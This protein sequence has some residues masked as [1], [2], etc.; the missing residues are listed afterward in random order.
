MAEPWWSF[1]R[2]R[3]QWG[4]VGFVVASVVAGVFAT[5]DLVGVPLAFNRASVELVWLSCL[6][7]IVAC[8]VMAPPSA[9]RERGWPQQPVGRWRIL[10]VVFLLCFPFLPVLATMLARGESPAWTLWFWRNHL[11]LAGTGLCLSR[12]LPPRVLWAPLAGYTLLCWFVGT[13]DETGRAWPWALVHLQPYDIGPAVFTVS[14]VAL[15]LWGQWRG[16]S[17]SDLT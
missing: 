15:G 3:G 7:P 6:P 10:W 8:A 1:V 11:L 17:R 9:E 13:R 5:G 14:V 16:P 2:S 4:A 12:W